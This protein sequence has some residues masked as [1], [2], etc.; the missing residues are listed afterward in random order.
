[1][2]YINIFRLALDLLRRKVMRKVLNT[3]NHREKI[4]LKAI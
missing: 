3:E 2:K 1:M 4:S